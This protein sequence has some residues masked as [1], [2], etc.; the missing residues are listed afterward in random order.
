MELF[1]WQICSPSLKQG[2]LN[3]IKIWLK[4]F[5]IQKAAIKVHI[6]ESLYSISGISGE[7]DQ[8]V[9]LLSIL[10]RQ[11]PDW[12]AEPKLFNSW[13]PRPTEQLS[14]YVTEGQANFSKTCFSTCGIIYFNI[15]TLCLFIFIFS[16]WSGLSLLIQAPSLWLPIE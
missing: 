4:R 16:I 12:Q 6:H 9:Q 1:Y 15:V 14:Y 8:F 5:G 7:L 11:R 3:K 13:C 2:N 10:T